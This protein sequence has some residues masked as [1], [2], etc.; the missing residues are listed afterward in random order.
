MKDDINNFKFTVSIFLFGSKLGYLILL[1]SLTMK[2][3]INRKS[4]T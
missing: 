2:D 1:N 3:D 4:I